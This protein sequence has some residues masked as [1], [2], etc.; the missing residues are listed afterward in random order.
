MVF[1]LEEEETPQGVQVEPKE[2]VLKAIGRH[3]QT[4][5]RHAAR[6]GARAAEAILGTPGD[7]YGTIESAL[8]GGAKLLGM[9]EEQVEKASKIASYLSPM[10]RLPTSTQLKEQITEPLTGEF[11]KPRGKGEEFAD[12]MV[13]DAAALILSRGRPIK[14]K[15]YVKQVLGSI[16]VSAGANTASEG[17]GLLGAGE[18]TQMAVKVG[19]MM[20]LGLLGKGKPERYVSKLYKEANDAIKHNPSV[21]ATALTKSVTRLYHELSEGLGAASEKAVMTKIEKLLAKVKNGKINVKELIAS[22]RSLSE[23]MSKVVFESADRASK[24]RAR[25]LFKKVSSDIRQEIDIYG[26]KNP[27][28]GKAYKD[29]E[30]G[31]GALQ[32]SQKVG[33]FIHKNA[34]YSPASVLLYPLVH[35]VGKATFPALAAGAALY[36]TA[37]I[38]YRLA[39][40]SALRTHY[41]NVLKHAAQENAPAMNRSLKK[42]D[43]A[44][45]KDEGKK[46]SKARFVLED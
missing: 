9:P 15:R 4:I 19:S 35:A 37:Q 25:K 38:G 18:K 1:V 42:L 34:K 13:G 21:D 39:K 44:L 24:S 40:S 27:K 10:G 29:A 3:A 31:F 20:L 8:G 7:I 32:Q 22:K 6:S 12:E 14:S 36:K 41:K 43:E 16:G 2:G 46:P 28:F 30:E 33:N 17:V 45:I 26:K 5:D 11:L 23:E